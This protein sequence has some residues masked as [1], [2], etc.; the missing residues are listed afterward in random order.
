MINLVLYS[1]GEIFDKTKELLIKTIKN[2][3]KNR[4]KIHEYNLEKISNLDWFN[5]IKLLPNVFIDEN[6]SDGWRKHGKRDGYFNSW[7]AFITLDVY[8]KMDKDEI[9]YYVD[10]SQW[11]RTGF[12]E[13]IDKLCEIIKKYKFI[14][15]SVGD[16]IKNDDIHPPHCCNNLK[17]WNKIIPNN[18]NK[19]LL[20]KNTVLNSWYI[21]TKNDTNEM[22]LKDWV[23]WST[24]SDNYLKDPLVTYHHTGD[25]TLLYGILFHRLP[26]LV[27]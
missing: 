20:K 22:F 8:N 27:F 5:K 24:Y 3:S 26:V 9:L 23:Y 15:G 2:N 16:D 11:V 14:D 7:K 12:T 19:L 4:I 18:N 17:V 1:N 21:L 13:N 25:Q 6:E 10:C